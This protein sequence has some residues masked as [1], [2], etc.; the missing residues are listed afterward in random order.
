MTHG[1]Q[2]AKDKHSMAS[3]EPK[4]PK[5]SQILSLEKSTRYE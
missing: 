3:E 5:A 1:Q 2:K 4:N